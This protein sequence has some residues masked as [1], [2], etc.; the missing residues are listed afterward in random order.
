M[1]MSQ[2]ASS[3]S[4]AQ[5]LETP[6]STESNVRTSLAQNI[7]EAI[8]KVLPEDP[9]GEIEKLAIVKETEGKF[10]VTPN[11]GTGTINSKLS[12]W[13]VSR[14]FKLTGSTPVFLNISATKF[15]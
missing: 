11:I 4:N 15:K 5:S 12:A 7:V 1:T 2:T 10:T 14:N 3:K 8:D 6:H 9:E 13:I